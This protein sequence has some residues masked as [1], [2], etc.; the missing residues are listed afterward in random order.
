MSSATDDYRVD[1]E[2][3]DVYD[4][5]GEYAGNLADDYD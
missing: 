2:T 4:P 3:G 1:P 5:E